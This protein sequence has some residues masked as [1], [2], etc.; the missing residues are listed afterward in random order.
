VDDLWLALDVVESGGRI[1][2]EPTAV[3][4]ELGTTDFGEEWER[5]TRRVA[6]ALDALWRR[7]SMLRPGSPV[8]DQLWGHRLVRSSLGPAAHVLLLAVAL[9]SSR[10]S[11]LARLFLQGH[12]A[13]IGALVR[14]SR[15]AELSAPERLLAQVLFLQAVGLAGTIRWLSGERSGGAWSKEERTGGLPPAGPDRA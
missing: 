9:G 13:G 8:A 10:R 1:V 2:Y 15:G 5:R 3:A 11:R 6:G 14:K 7:R 12:M 4:A